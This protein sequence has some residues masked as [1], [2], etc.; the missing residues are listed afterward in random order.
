[1][2][3]SKTGTSPPLGMRSTTVAPASFRDTAVSGIPRAAPSQAP[4][5]LTRL[6]L[7]RRNK[8]LC[9]H[10]PFHADA[11]A[12]HER[13]HPAVQKAFHA[14]NAERARERDV[15]R[16]KC[17]SARWRRY[18]ASRRRLA[19]DIDEAR[20]RRSDARRTQARRRRSRS[21]STSNGRVDV[22]EIDTDAAEATDGVGA[23]GAVGAA[24]AHDFA[25]ANQ[26]GCAAGAE[27]PGAA[28]GGCSGRG[29]AE[30]AKLSPTE[31]PRADGDLSRRKDKFVTFAWDEDEGGGAGKGGGGG[32]WSRFCSCLIETCAW[33]QR[34]STRRFTKMTD[35]RWLTL[36]SRS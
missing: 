31:A 23:V 25:L 26:K 22:Y 13:A 35:A 11:R 29:C 17:S 1:M 10:A 2:H 18:L 8:A 14:Q 4:S 19:R 3:P 34:L 16:S 12:Q 21:R 28:V 15:T 24:V 36:R 5:Q 9:A 30:P 32:S 20:S 6:F 33:C 27:A 7:A